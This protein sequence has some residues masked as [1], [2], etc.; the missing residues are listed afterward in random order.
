MGEQQSQ[1]GD[2][3]QKL[4]ELQRKQE[5]F[6]SEILQVKEELERLGK[7]QASNAETETPAAN[8]SLKAESRAA[9]AT[10]EVK[11][12]P[13]NPEVTSETSPSAFNAADKT[14]GKI[15]TDLERFIG[16]NLIN[17]IGIA[18]TVIGVGIGAKYAIDHRLISPL[19]RIVMGYL[20]GLGLLF[21]AVWLKKQYENFSAVLLSGS[22]AIMYFITYAAYSF[23]GFYPQLAAFTLM[24]IFTT[25]TVMAALRYNREI[26]AVIGMVGAFAVPYLLSEGS[27]KVLIFFSYITI[28]NSGIM[29]IALKKY[30]KSLYLSAFAFT[31]LVYFTWLAGRYD[32][33]KDFGLAV[34]FLFIFFIIF[35]VAFLSY[36]LIKKDK[37][38]IF[39]I[40]LLLINSFIFYGTG[41]YILKGHP[42]GDEQ[43]GLFTVANAALHIIIGATIYR[44][45]LADRNLFYFISGLAVVF[46]TIAIPVQLNG[47]WVTLLWICEAMILFSIGRIRHAPVYENISYPLIVMAFYSL[48]D[49]WGKMQ[50]VSG[51]G[52]SVVEFTPVF[53][54]QFFS[55]LIFIAALSVILLIHFSKKYPSP[56]KEKKSALDMINYGLPFLLILVVYLTFR[57]EITL[58]YNHLTE[59]S[60]ILPDGNNIQSD[61]ASKSD[62]VS[63]RTIWLCNY[64]LLFFA[65]LSLI[66]TRKIKNSFLGIASFWLI[67]ITVLVFLFQSLYILSDLR[68][69][70]IS[71]GSS[72]DFS[73]TDFRLSI[74]Y[75]S[76]VFVTIA[77]IS[78]KIWTR[79]MDVENYYKIIFSLLFHLTILWILCSEM[80]NIMDLLRN[81]HSYKFGL[82]I[83]SGLYALILIVLGIIGKK[84]YLRIAAMALLGVTLAKLFFYDI[85]RLDTI[86]KTILFLALGILMLLVSFLYNKYKIR[87]YGE[88]GGQTNYTD[89]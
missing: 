13:A 23:Y 45:R 86:L 42:P 66:N 49:D 3:Q 24:V 16:E 18:I 76:F 46:L 65:G 31:W 80:L 88:P 59:A 48:V 15:R 8:N 35:Y 47:N 67:F 55:S 36:K 72:R 32:A 56:L 20:V 41:F 87:L 19:A 11:G 77:L 27:E 84:R 53:N 44:N 58:Y 4:N 57:T 30:W 37:F 38:N 68:E 79:K 7:K 71:N 81:T 61:L 54:I 25:F 43:L 73:L 29:I 74:R 1:L 9:I 83:L 75:I 89:N 10:A 78:L 60:K 5:L 40:L 62:F 26:I 28:I 39:D 63:F 52:S 64:S 21:F 14:G 17:K 2:L 33:G 22:L 69:S 6:H 85:S 12:I 82:S 51:T 34:A 70:L 50:I